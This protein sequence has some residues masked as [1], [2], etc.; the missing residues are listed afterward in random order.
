MSGLRRYLGYFRPYVLQLVG[1]GML[2]AVIAAVPGAAAL[3]LKVTVDTVLVAG[4]ADAVLPLAL[5]Y[6]ALFALQGGLSLLRT[7]LSKALAWRVTA[8]LRERVFAR[9]LALSPRQ[10]QHTGQRLARL[11]DEVDEVQ[12]GVSALVTALRNPLELLSLGAVALFLA[13]TLTLWVVPS[14]LL[15]AVLVRRSSGWVRRLASERTRARAQLVE[16]LTDQLGGWRTLQRYGVEQTEL[17]RF[18][19]VNQD[20]RRARLDLDVGRT[21]PSVLTRVV[22]AMGLG[23]LLVAGGRQVAAGTLAP[24]DLV[25]FGAA[26]GAMT[27]PLS[28]LSELVSLLSRSLG[29]L[30][31]V[32][33]VLDT[34]PDV[35][36]PEAPVALPDGPLGVRFEDVAVDYGAGPVLTGVDLTV[37]AGAL[38]VFVGASGGGKTSLL[39]AL[40]REVA[41]STGRVL[42]GGV[43]VEGLA[44]EALRGAVA[45]V[46][47]D[48]VLFDRTVRENLDLG[49]RCGEATLWRALEQAEAADFV[50]ALPEGLDTR[51]GQLGE[52]LSGGQRQRLGL[53]RALASGARVLVL[54]EITAQLDAHT[55][56]A[57]LATLERLRGERTLLVVAHRLQAAVPADLVVVLEHGRLVEQGTHVSLLTAAGP[58]ARLWQAREAG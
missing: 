7:R 38:A 53:A 15:V 20:D 19:R 42:L 1:I 50:R 26:L 55:E 22:A 10:Q 29:A 54:D 40:T 21:V 44:V 30:E 16:L 23:V 47:Q 41:P 32:H 45:V 12:Y 5:A 18:S 9:L 48:E 52:R 46:A 13:P 51:V 39:R 43:D 11:T 34:P 28:G 17:V 31:R 35:C 49:G 37:E 8:R 57:L 27:R 33:Q 36:S 24:G 14:F 3:L 6:V 56:A 58:Y 25:A 2:V 4:D